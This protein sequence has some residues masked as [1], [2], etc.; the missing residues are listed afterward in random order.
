[1]LVEPFFA[2]ARAY[3]T[4]GRFS[5]TDLYVANFLGGTIG[6]YTT[7]GATVNAALI[8]G[9]YLPTGVAVTNSVPEPCTAALFGIASGL[10]AM[11]RR[12]VTTGCP[13]G[14]AQDA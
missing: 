10:L 11:Q 6:E 14:R 5:H 12:C 7:S 3:L 4:L 13:P 1:M 9:L 2:K 8:S